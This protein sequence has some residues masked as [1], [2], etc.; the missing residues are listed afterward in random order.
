MT[1]CEE[2]ELIRSISYQ[3]KTGDKQNT[4]SGCL[5]E[6]EEISGCTVKILRCTRCGNI[7]IMWKREE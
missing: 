6:E 1:E 3:K 4:V 2:N 5:Y 7:E